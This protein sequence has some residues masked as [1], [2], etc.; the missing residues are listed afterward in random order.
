MSN[1]EKIVISIALTVIIALVSI[2]LTIQVFTVNNLLAND[3]I[4]TWPERPYYVDEET[5]ERLS[6]ISALENG[7]YLKPFTE[8]GY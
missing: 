8:Y 7:Q 1:V 3:C 5:W 2:S 4:D 6:E